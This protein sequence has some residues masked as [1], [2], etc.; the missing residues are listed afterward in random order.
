MSNAFDITVQSLRKEGM[1]SDEILEEVMNSKELSKLLPN[2]VDSNKKSD[3]DG[4]TEAKIKMLLTQLG[5]PAKIR[6]YNCWVTAIRLYKNARGKKLL[7][8]K[9]IY[10]Q[11]ATI[12]GLTVAMV[13]KSMRLAVECMFDRCS[14]DTIESMFGKNLDTQRGK[15]T[16][17]E[18]LVVLSEKI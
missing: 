15:I 1:N 3:C 14:A 8:T 16:N 17:L 11:V 12:L 2:L 7:I 18:F 13:E 10:P 9:D 4:D 5:M 6:G